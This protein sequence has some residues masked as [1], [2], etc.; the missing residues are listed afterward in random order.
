MSPPACGIETLR[1]V[2]FSQAYEL[3]SRCLSLAHAHLRSRSRPETS[4]LG[5]LPRACHRCRCPAIMSGK[6]FSEN[7]SGGGVRVL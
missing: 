4:I 3:V 7:V 5:H 2:A 1:G 6:L